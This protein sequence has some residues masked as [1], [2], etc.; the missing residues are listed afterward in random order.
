MK[1][2]RLAT[3]DIKLFAFERL[4][5][6]L[7][8]CDHQVKWRTSGLILSGFENVLCAPFELDVEELSPVI[9]RCKAPRPFK[10]S[11]QCMI[12]RSA[13]CGIPLLQQLDFQNCV[14]SSFPL[15]MKVPS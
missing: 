5:F 4:S 1:N 12:V 2:R 11:T 7:I 9:Q 6:T 10:S 3:S 13:L 14:F 8:H 15:P